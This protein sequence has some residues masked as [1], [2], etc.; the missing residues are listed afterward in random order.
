MKRA[1]AFG[2]ALIAAAAMAAPAAAGPFGYGLRFGANFAD[3]RGDFA[4][5]ANPTM[6]VGTEGGLYVDYAISP[7]LALQLDVDYVTKGAAFESVE[8]D[9]VGNPIGTLDSKLQL[10]YV[11]V[12]LMVRATVHP[13]G[14]G[15]PAPYLIGGPSL[16]IKLD[17][18]FENDGVTGLADQDV[19]GDMNEFLWGVT[20]GLGL[21]FPTETL[22]LAVEA[23]YRTDF[24]DL[25]DVDENYQSI[26][27]GLSV[28]FL[29][30]R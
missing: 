6:K 5:I 16:S 30:S 22:G 20:G 29:I 15:A 27:H 4:E 7:D 21:R 25:W 19:S 3:L 11:E 14:A 9:N 10:R 26:N 24:G 23:R 13:W 17:G 2:M 18:T 28:T 8:T 12:P 1:A